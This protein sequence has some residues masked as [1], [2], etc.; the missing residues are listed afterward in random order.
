MKKII[1]AG[2]GHGGLSAAA[3]LAKNGFDVTVIEKKKREELGYDWC[4]SMRK[5]TFEKADIPLPDLS[6]FSPTQRKTYSNPKRSVRLEIPKSNS[7][8]I[9]FV[10]RKFLIGYLI[11]Y[12]VKCSVK[13]IFDCEVLSALCTEDGVCGVVAVKNGVETEYE[14]QLV[15]DAAGINSPVR[16]SLPP[17]FGIE[18][19]IKSENT[20]G[21]WRGYFESR[22]KLSEGEYD[23]YFYHMNRPGMDWVIK[24]DGYCDVLVGAFG[25]L[26]ENDVKTALDD[27]YAIYPEMSDKL[28]RGGSF[29]K[30]P[31]GKTL[32]LF[33]CDGCALVGDSASMTEPL[34]GSGLDMSIIAG[35]MLAETVTECDDMKKETL[36]KYNLRFFR[37]HTEK[38]YS[39]TAVKN[40]LSGVSA[41]D[42]DFLFEKKLMTEK[43]ITGGARVSYSPAEIAQKAAVI[44]R[45]KLLLS[46]F[47]L[48]KRLNAAKK[49][50]KLMP[51]KYNEKAIEK[52]KKV[53]SK[54]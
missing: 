7:G 13:F 3:N 6:V 35:R 18:S 24:N 52:F 19:E 16:K 50:K 4:D 49:A 26:C 31:L 5:S 41:E 38:H 40:F 30:I 36:W 21:V 51:D 9:V 53:Y 34:S 45:P 15:V 1:V 22:E 39:D 48:L 11:D 12:A 28:I 20:F 2:C 32:P 23:I 29:E 27:F 43:E 42:V 44:T 46:L 54:L 37:E 47:G 10:D 17:S 14:A 33:V 8:N 25:A